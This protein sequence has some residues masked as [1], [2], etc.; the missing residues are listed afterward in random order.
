M[1]LGEEIREG[2]QGATVECF[3]YLGNEGDMMNLNLEQKRLITAAPGGATLVRGVAGSGKTTVAVQRAE[4]LLKNYC[5]DEEDRIL[6]VT[7]NNTLVRY[8]RYL[9]KKANVQGEDYLSLFGAT[10]ANVDITTVDSLFSRYYFKFFDEC[11]RK[12]LLFSNQKAYEV[13]KNC[14][15][16]LGKKF[17]NTGL[18]DPQNAAFLKDELDWIR[19]CNYMELSEYQNVDRL[20][21]QSMKQAEGPQRLRKNSETRQAIYELMLAVDARLD[22][23]G[24][25]DF[26]LRDIL[27]L[28]RAREVSVPKYTHIIVD[29]TQDLTRV[30]LQLLQLLHKEGD[31]SSIFFVI[32]TAQSIYSHSWLV[33]GRSFTSIGLDLKGKGTI[34]SKNYRTTT[35]IAKAAYSLIEGTDVVE[36][37]YFVEP[38][39]LDRQGQFPVCRHFVSEKNEAEFVAEEIQGLQGRYQLREI[40]VIARMY[41]QLEMVRLELEEQGL[42]CRLLKERDS[43]F[44]ED[45]VKLLTMHSIKGLEFKVVFIIGLSDSVI[46]YRI[47]NDLDDEIQVVTERKLLYV[48]MTRASELLYLSSWERPSRFIKSIAPEYLRLTGSCRFSHLYN[49]RPDA[50]Q[51]GEK[52]LDVFSKEE[53]VR[54]WLLRE[55]QEKY[56]YPRT[57]LDVEYKVNN[58]S[59]KGS[60]D[61]CVQISRDGC[62]Q[63][64]VFCEV[65]APGSGIKEGL[66]QVKSY[67][68]NAKHCQYGLVTDGQEVAII[69]ADFQPVEDIPAFSRYM[70]PPTMERYIFH[71]FSSKKKYTMIRDINL[72]QEVIVETAAGSEAFSGSN[73][74]L[75]STYEGIAAGQPI[76]MQSKTEAKFYLPTPW[77]RGWENCY[78]LKVRGDSMIEAGIEDQDFVLIREQSTAENRDIVAVAIGDEAT[79]KRYVRMGSTVLLMPENPDY[80]PIQLQDN[81]ARIVGVAVGLLKKEKA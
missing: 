77:L 3:K 46:P 21:R 4:F 13:I 66:D 72:S 73:L 62:L 36:D 49:I 79:L 25:I 74:K 35:Q 22:E 18:M 56:C 54:Q 76:Y 34:L 69:N 39:L 15:A 78:L 59:Q 28:N 81:D 43:T 52:I 9:Y 71:C 12:A 1:P 48:G 30:Q 55:L 64:Y 61:I 5:I 45:C 38:A 14:A 11:Q 26:K 29:E 20:G 67:M 65:K 60:V 41:R 44:D 23:E 10:P 17:P 33:R 50:Y 6:L 8:L 57:L 7:Y 75:V 70:L 32:D 58:M 24:L 63:P 37:E 40:I 2:I 68:S 42:A 16:E 47:Y 31:Y 53:K 80:E 19:S 27:V 51:F